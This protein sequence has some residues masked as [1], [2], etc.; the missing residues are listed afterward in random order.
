MIVS[1]A[2][3]QSYFD[4]VRRRTRNFCA[5][6]PPERMDWAPLSGEFTCGDIIRHLA[7]SEQMFVSVALTG[8]WTYPGHDRILGADIQGALAYLEASH[9]S[10]TAALATLDD[11]ALD[12]TRKGVGGH[13]IKVWRILMLMAEHEIHHRSQLATYLSLAGIEPPQIYGMHLEDVIAYAEREP[14]RV[15]G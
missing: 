7:A 5:V 6:V 12:V 3:F 2:A 13:A 8:R 14:A 9:T 4:S 15:Q 10:A 1:I 11:A